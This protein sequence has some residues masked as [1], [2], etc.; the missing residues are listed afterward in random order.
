MVMMSILQT[1]SYNCVLFVFAFIEIIIN[2][3][4]ESSTKG[5]LEYLS[6]YFDTLYEELFYVESGCNKYPNLKIIV[7]KV[8]VQVKN[9]KKIIVYRKCHREDL[10]NL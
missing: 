4:Q 1:D 7:E 10:I 5:L 9:Q 2:L 8:I 3:Y 6:K